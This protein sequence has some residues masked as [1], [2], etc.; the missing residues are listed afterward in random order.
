ME[1]TYDKDCRVLFTKCRVVIYNK[2]DKPFLTGWR[3]LTGSKL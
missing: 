3:E 1:Y 2:R